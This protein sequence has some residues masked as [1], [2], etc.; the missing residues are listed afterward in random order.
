[1]SKF[2]EY[3][4]MFLMV[5][6]L[7]LSIFS[8]FSTPKLQVDSRGKLLQTA[9]NEQYYQQKS[10]GLGS[11][12]GDLKDMGNVQHLG[13]HPLKY[14]ECLKKVDPAFLRQATGKTLNQLIG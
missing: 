5:S 2:S 7:A 11:D 13:H 10:A 8:F 6:V 12:C 4:L 1:M 3:G 9:S 14:A